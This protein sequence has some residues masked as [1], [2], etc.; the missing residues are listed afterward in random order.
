MKTVKT[1]ARRLLS[2]EREIPGDSGFR[3]MRKSVEFR[4][5]SRFGA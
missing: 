1:N 2:H 4:F 3:N 5:F